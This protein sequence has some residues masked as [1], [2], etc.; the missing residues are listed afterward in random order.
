MMKLDSSDNRIK[1]FRYK[2][3]SQVLL[4]LFGQA[5]FLADGCFDYT[6]TDNIDPD[7]SRCE[8]NRKGVG[9]TPVLLQAGSEKRA[10]FRQAQPL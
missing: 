1:S 9:P 10:G 5:K 7:A 6:G 3:L 4:L 2:H 8:F